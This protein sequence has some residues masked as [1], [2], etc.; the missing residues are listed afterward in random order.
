MISS[1]ILE[2][3]SDYILYMQQKKI[4]TIS[5]EGH[6]AN[7]ADLVYNMHLNKIN[8]EIT[9]L[10]L[11]LSEKNDK[12]EFFLRDLTPSTAR[13]EINHNK[14]N[15]KN[16][17]K[18]AIKFGTAVFNLDELIEKK[19]IPKASKVKIDVDGA[20]YLILKGFSNNLKYVDEIM[21]EMY[22]K[23]FDI[24]KCYD[25]YKYNDK[26]YTKDILENYYGT[27]SKKI[28]ILTK[29]RNY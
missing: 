25:D 4:R 9:I 16:E 27:S 22:E 21:I 1:L 29:L 24:W 7:L 18:E 2:Q 3:I 15:F 12:T 8:G 13:S 20:E 5:I 19:I 23:P 26:I 17:N 10:P 6:Y 14:N 28:H 11:L